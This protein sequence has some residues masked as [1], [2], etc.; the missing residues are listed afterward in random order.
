MQWPEVLCR[1]AERMKTRA[2]LGARGTV[3]K[4]R[5]SEGGTCC[6]FARS[7]RFG[8]VWRAWKQAQPSVLST[9]G[10]NCKHP[11]TGL[12]EDRAQIGFVPLLERTPKVR[13]RLPVECPR[14]APWVVVNVRCSRATSD[15]V[16]SSLSW[17]HNTPFSQRRVQ[18]TL[19]S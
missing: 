5:A 4:L 17:T 7:E 19:A 10:A 9:A 11:V 14:L 2:S 8:S 13:R 12:Q 6:R 3:S 18:V 1:T 16:R 15:V